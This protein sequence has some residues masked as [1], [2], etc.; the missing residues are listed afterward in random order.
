MRTA[1]ILLSL[2]LATAAA[3]CASN[4]PRGHFSCGFN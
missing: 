1:A 4:C 2:F 3:G